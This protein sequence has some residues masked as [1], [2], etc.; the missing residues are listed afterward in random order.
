M[1]EQIIP[2]SRRIMATLEI[3][4]HFMSVDEIETLELFRQHVYDLELRHLTG[5]VLGGQSRFPQG[6]ENIMEMRHDS[7][8]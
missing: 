4:R 1:V 5:I 2:N 3:N 7:D 6:M 8:T